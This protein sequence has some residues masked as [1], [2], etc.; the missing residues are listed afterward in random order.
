MEDMEN[1][2][3]SIGDKAKSMVLTIFIVI[4][5]LYFIFGTFTIVNF[6]EQRMLVFTLEFSPAGLASGDLIEGWVFGNRVLET[7]YGEITLNHWSRILAQ[8]HGIFEITNTSF[9]RGRA[10]HNLSIDD[11]IELPREI[12]IRIDRYGQFGFLF[13]DHQE[14]VISGVPLVVNHIR[15]NSRDNPNNLTFTGWTHLCNDIILIL[16][17]ETQIS[18]KEL[19]IIWVMYFHNESET[20]SIRAAHR[21]YFLVKLP[22]ETEFRRYTSI[23]F[24]QHWGDFIEGIPFEG[25]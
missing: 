1:K 3:E 13:L 4:S 5:V 2:K 12:S 21:D 24:G 14:V 7:K 19:A 15:F 23:T 10:V 20:W 18:F 6:K 9:Q 16:L 8:D 25:T 17:D 22:G 11:G